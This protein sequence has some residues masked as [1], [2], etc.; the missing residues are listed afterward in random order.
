MIHPRCCLLCCRVG[1]AAAA[2]AECCPCALSSP[3]VCQ[4]FATFHMNLPAAS[5]ALPLPSPLRGSV[6]LRDC[7]EAEAGFLLVQL[8]KAALAG[9]G[10]LGP[11]PAPLPPPPPG[12]PPAAAAS[13]RVV[14]LAA[15]QSAS[16]YSAVL[17]KAGL[18]L[19]TLVGA[20]QLSVVELLPA[21][22]APA[23]LPSL[24]DVHAR[25]AAVLT[26]EAAADSRQ[27]SGICLIVDD[28]TALHCLADS[29][30]D[31]AA[32]LHACLA[33]GQAPAGAFVGLAHSGIPD[34]ERWLAQ[35]EH[36]AAVVID[37]E[38]LESG[39]SAD[40]TG[41]LAVTVRD[42]LPARLLQQ[43]GPGQQAAPAEAAAGGGGDG[44]VAP[45]TRHFCYRLGETGARYI[46][47]AV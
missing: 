5:A 47:Q 42:A 4:S 37:V 36:A 16:H 34:D 8:I 45:G 26:G 17:R 19:P 31:W 28:L 18:S 21:L 27:N 40:L 24:R 38:P 25:L 11:P 39:R 20:G 15:A 46:E 29:P 44:G 41:R 23:G 6:L 30:A 43:A 33:V 32:F 12:Q 7:L 22:A 14:L 3:P 2:A 35:L 10:A 13:C 9:E 1:A